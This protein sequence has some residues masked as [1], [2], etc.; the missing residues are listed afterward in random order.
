MLIDSISLE[1]IAT[2]GVLATLAIAVAFGPELRRILGR[3]RNRRAADVSNAPS[4]GAEPQ[5]S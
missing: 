1:R 2:A 4:L 3:M 5:Q